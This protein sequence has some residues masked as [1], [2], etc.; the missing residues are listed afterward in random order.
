MKDRWLRFLIWLS[1]G[2]LRRKPKPLL[3][4][5]YDWTRRLEVMDVS[6]GGT[7]KDGV[8]TATHVSLVEPR[9]KP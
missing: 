1:R 2:E 9:T 3:V 8:F 7:M 4:S 6:L 5:F